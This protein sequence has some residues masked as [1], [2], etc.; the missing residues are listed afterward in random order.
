MANAQNINKMEDGT[1][2]GLGKTH[3]CISK[4]KTKKM[5]LHVYR[6]ICVF[7]QEEKTRKNKENNIYMSTFLIIVLFKILSNSFYCWLCK[8]PLPQ[9]PICYWKYH[10]A[11]RLKFKLDVCGI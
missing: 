2:C 6:I 7:E 1:I 11:E 3:L 8:S 9:P 10:L 4:Y 5:Q